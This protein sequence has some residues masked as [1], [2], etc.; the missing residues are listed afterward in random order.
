[1]CFGSLFTVNLPLVY[2]AIYSMLKSLLT[3]RY[4]NQKSLEKRFVCLFSKSSVEYFKR[5]RQKQ[6]HPLFFF[7]SVTSNLPWNQKLET[8]NVHVS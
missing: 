4:N 7:P 5:N 8:L 6:P 1:M 3:A 2:K